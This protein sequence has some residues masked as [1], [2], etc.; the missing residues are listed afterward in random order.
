MS[1]DNP[2][3]ARVTVN[4]QWQAFFGRGLVR[5]TEDF[6]FQGE[7]PT[8]PELLDWLAVEFV[9]QRLVDEE[10]APADRHQ[11]D[12]PPVVAA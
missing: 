5:T 10:A 1:P 9:E 12:L 11:R 2:L 4:R 3:T 8:H 6:G 7:P